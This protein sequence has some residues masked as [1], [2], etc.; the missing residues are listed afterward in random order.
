MIQG[1]YIR[2]HRETG[3]EQ[4]ISDYFFDNDI[5][6]QC[7]VYWNA[8]PRREYIPTNT[9]SVGYDT[10]REAQN[11]EHPQSLLFRE[12]T[13]YSNREPYTLRHRLQIEP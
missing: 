8:D 9:H 10:F 5:F 2:R 13:Y 1:S 12:R 6:L 7:I 3:N 4:Y 11:K